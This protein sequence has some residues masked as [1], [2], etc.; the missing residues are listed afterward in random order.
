MRAQKLHCSGASTNWTIP[1]ASLAATAIYSKLNANLQRWC[2]KWYQL[3]YALIHYHRLWSWFLKKYGKTQI[4]MKRERLIQLHWDQG[5][6]YIKWQSVMM[7]QWKLFLFHIQQMTWH[8]IWKYTKQFF[9]RSLAN[10]GGQKGGIHSPW[11]EGSIRVSSAFLWHALTLHATSFRK[12]CGWWEWARWWARTHTS[13]W[14]K[15]RWRRNEG[16]P[17]RGVKGFV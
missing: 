16:W 13:G 10:S 5:S 8:Y 3:S 17:L 7:I 12:G 6:S 9:V 4:S 14:T 1:K 2:G 15:R 11:R